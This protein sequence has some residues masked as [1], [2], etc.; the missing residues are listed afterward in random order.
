MAKRDLMR[1]K[2]KILKANHLIDNHNPNQSIESN[3]ELSSLMKT[4]CKMD[5]E[6]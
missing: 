6:L 2:E 4:L 1:L 3:S 5:T